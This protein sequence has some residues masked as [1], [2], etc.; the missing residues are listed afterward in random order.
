MLSSLRRGDLTGVIMAVESRPEELR[1]VISKVPQSVKVFFK[2]ITSTNFRAESRLFTLRAN[3]DSSKL[4][5]GF[6]QKVNCQNSL[7]HTIMLDGPR[8]GAA[9]NA[10][11]DFGVQPMH[12]ACRSKC[13]S[14]SLPG[15]DSHVTIRVL[16]VLL[17]SVFLRWPHPHRRVAASHASHRGAT[18]DKNLNSYAVPLAM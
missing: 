18:G 2:S 1:D 11:A 15:N 4:H 14:M 9:P 16:R 13:V 17:H 7:F 3:V 12:L 5:S 10:R 8:T 6:T